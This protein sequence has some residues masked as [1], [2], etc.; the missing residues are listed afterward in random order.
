M[1]LRLNGSD[2][3]R[4]TDRKWPWVKRLAHTYLQEQEGFEG[5]QIQ[6][7]VKKYEAIW[8]Q[9]EPSGGHTVPGIF[10]LPWQNAWWK[11]LKGKRILSGS[12]FE[13]PSWS[14]GNAGAGTCCRDFSAL[15]GSESQEWRIKALSWLQSGPLGHKTVTLTFLV[16]SLLCKVLSHMP[17][18]VSPGDP[19]SNCSNYKNETL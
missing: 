4:H 13:G 15:Q 12:G 5:T 10:S 17:T 7:H 14:G 1:L 19:K 2:S 9:K 16:T 6:S 18:G 8:K 11:L 3:V